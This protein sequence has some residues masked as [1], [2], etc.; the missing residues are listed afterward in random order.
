VRPSLPSSLTLFSLSIFFTS[1]FFCFHLRPSSPPSQTRPRVPTPRVLPCPAPLCPVL[2]PMWHTRVISHLTGFLYALP[3]PSPSLI[4]SRNLL[5][6]LALPSMGDAFTLLGNF[7]TRL[8]R[9]SDLTIFEPGLSGA[10]CGSGGRLRV[11]RVVVRDL[12]SF[13][14]LFFL[15]LWGFFSPFFDLLYRTHR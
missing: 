13:P 12:F 8:R 6:L 11:R 10:P 15:F 1:T 9:F 14:S 5:P 7:L 2:S 3:S 4:L